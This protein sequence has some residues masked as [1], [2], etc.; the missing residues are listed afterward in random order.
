M[1]DLNQPWFS[2]RSL[3][4]LGVL[5]VTF[6]GILW[7]FHRPLVCKTG[8]GIWAAAW[9]DCT[10]QHLLDAYTF[11]HVLHGVI[12][13]WLLRPL[14]GRLSLPWRLIVAMSLEVGWE[15]LENSPVIIEH[16]RNNTASFNY[17][18]DSILNSLGDLLA[19]F[20]G[21]VFASRTSWKWAVAIF[22]LLELAALYLSRDNLTLN[23]LM[24]LYPIEAIIDW[25]WQASPKMGHLGLTQEA[26]GAM[27]LFVHFPK[28]RPIFGHR[29]F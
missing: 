20:G 21:F 26:F 13:Y 25:Q 7:L 17:A 1:T 18:G 4:T 11:S 14:A 10:S 27:A 16:Y 9:T 23:V 28:Y 19:T 6:I 22:V 24:F 15:L 12:F 8:F 5:V 2:R 3:V 29:C